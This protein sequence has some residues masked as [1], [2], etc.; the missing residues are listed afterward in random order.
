MASV[1]RRKKLRDYIFNHRYQGHQAERVAWKWHEAF[2]SQNLV[3]VT[4]FCQEATPPKPHK[5]CYQM[6]L[7]VQMSPSMGEILI[8]TPL[9]HGQ[10]RGGCFTENTAC[11]SFLSAAMMN[12][13][14]KGLVGRKGFLL[15]YTLQPSVER[16]Q[17]RNSSGAGTCSRDHGGGLFTGLLLGSLLSQLS[18]STYQ[19]EYSANC[20]RPGSLKS[21]ISQ[22][23]LSQI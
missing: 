20:S 2:N 11:S 16:S 8:Q 9:R 15:L 12:T 19:V 5:Q 17:R 18:Y 23:T 1:S 22:G 6:E 13:T 21:V 10:L 4:C 3:L 14:M 7:H